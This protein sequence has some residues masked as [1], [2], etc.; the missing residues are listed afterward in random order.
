MNSVIK[1]FYDAKSRRLKIN[2]PFFLADLIRAFPS[3][4]F[5]PK[6]KMWA[7]PINKANM[8]CFNELC[9]KQQVELNEAAT[10]AI[11][12][13]ESRNTAPIYQP[14][15]TRYDFTRSKSK[16]L[17]M[18]HQWKLLNKSWGLEAA[19]WFAKMG[20]GKTFAA[21]HLACARHQ[22]GQINTVLVI[23][24]STLKNTW[25]KEFEKY[26]TSPYQF[27]NFD[28]KA[29]WID[30]FYSLDTLDL[31]VMAVS[32]EGL[33]VS[34]A[35]FDGVCGIFVKNNVMIILDES[36]R[37]KNPS[38]LRTKR[39]LEFRQASKYRII[40][41]GTPIAL[42]IQDLWAQYEFL[43][44]DIIGS[45]D[46]WAFKSRHLEM[47]GFESRQIIGYKNVEELMKAI[48]P[49]T[50]EV[51]KDVLNLPPKVYKQIYLTAT[52]EQKKYLKV[53]KAGFDE[54]N[55]VHVKVDNVLERILR[56][57]QIVGGWLPKHDIESNNV[58]LEPLKSN[59][60][61]DAL[62]S[63]VEDNIE[64]SKFI[65]WSTFIH[66]IEFIHKQLDL[67]F[68]DGCAVSYYGATTAEDRT[69]ALEAYNTDPKTKFF[70]GNPATAGLGLTLISGLNDVMVYYTNTNAYIDRMQSEDRAHRIGQK[71]TVTVID[72]VVEKT[73]DELILE[74]TKEKMSVEEYVLNRLKSGSLPEFLG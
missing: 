39:T 72:L 52:L 42:G 45:G 25:K 55:K 70:V 18:E 32:V 5:E 61:F 2:C 43:D 10:T 34:E 58:T 60:K 8:V 17:P 26:S 57:K 28:T 12:E 36:S 13:F 63:L 15:P 16:F 31:K 74:S 14:F 53:V 62:L 22:S 4:R 38:A 37:I 40:L 65:I 69:H 67:K 64:T 3:K 7:L 41:N 24:P 6:S 23:C 1:V 50:V 56:W 20:T 48:E 35:L 54:D 19:A 46:Y 21:I 11:A 44:P 68:G 73:V 49:Y 9:H 27:K 33:G 59:P 30:E 29:L 71:N 51:G 47:G 66:E